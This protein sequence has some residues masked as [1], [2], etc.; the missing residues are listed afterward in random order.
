[1]PKGAKA[2]ISV[3]SAAP[4]REPDQPPVLLVELRNT[5]RAH[6]VLDTIRLVIKSQ[7]SS[8]VASVLLTAERLTA[9]GGRN[10]LAGA[11]RQFK[12]AWPPG[13]HVGPVEVSLELL[14]R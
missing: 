6:K 12:M 9:L 11:T 10:I 13:L 7:E 1:M 8:Q 3:I 14:A 5:G 4:T 2:D